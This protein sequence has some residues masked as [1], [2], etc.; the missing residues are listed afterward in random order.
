M[1]LKSV[2][3]C[4]TFGNFPDVFLLFISNVFPTVVRESICFGLNLLVVLVIVLGIVVFLEVWARTDLGWY[5]W[6]VT[7]PLD[8]FM[9]FLQEVSPV[10]LNIL[11]KVITL[12]VQPH[13]VLL[14]PFCLQVPN[15]TFLFNP[16]TVGKGPGSKYF[17][18]CSM[19]PLQCKM[20]PQTTW[21]NK[22]VWMGFNKI[23]LQKQAWGWFE[24]RLANLWSGATCH[25]EDV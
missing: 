13:W 6:L 1:L 21:K 7:G 16:P 17:T 25:Y 24:S 18:L 14:R 19:L 11:A 22:W 5:L 12:Y 3:F 10:N 4:F 23:S 15:L 8:W 9:S 20:Q 2:Q